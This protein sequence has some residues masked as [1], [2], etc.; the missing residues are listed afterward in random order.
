MWK[1][2]HLYITDITYEWALTN[3]RA[4]LLM[5]LWDF[6]SAIAY[7]Y[8]TAIELFRTGQ[9]SAPRSFADVM[10]PTIST[11]TLTDRFIMLR[12]RKEIYCFGIEFLVAESSLCSL[13]LFLLDCDD[14]WEKLTFCAEPLFK[15]WCAMFLIVF[16]ENR[17]G[18]ELFYI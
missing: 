17:S 9:F 11:F 3:P 16:R 2:I 13:D 8:I 18:S 5:S 12:K 1:R 15:W 14:G 4:F 6:F 10:L 7:F